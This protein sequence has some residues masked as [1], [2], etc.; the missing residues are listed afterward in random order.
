M[1]R[2]VVV[3]TSPIARDELAEHLEP[4]DELSVVAPVVE[5]SRLDWLAND[6]GKAREGAQRIGESVAA[7]APV[8]ARDVEVT[9]D[10]PSQAVL[11]AVAQHDPDRVV[12][13]LRSGERATWL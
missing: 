10:S 4:G 3:A 13:V 8:D 11:D 9:P 7:R 1:T 12:V 6:E 5:Q 2:V